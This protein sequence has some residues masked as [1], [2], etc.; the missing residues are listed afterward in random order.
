MMWYRVCDTGGAYSN[1]EV[2]TAASLADFDLQTPNKNRHAE[3]Q[4]EPSLYT[5]RAETKRRL[6]RLREPQ[7][8]P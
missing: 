4:G 6:A 2:R 7:C 8:L 1:E 5:H 3:W